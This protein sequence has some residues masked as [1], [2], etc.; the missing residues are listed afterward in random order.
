MNIIDF[1]PMLKQQ[2]VQEGVSVKA[3][4][5]MTVGCGR[6]LKNF[7]L[8]NARRFYSLWGGAAWVKNL[9]NYLKCRVLTSAGPPYR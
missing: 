5:R 7:I 4:D 8:A 1:H 2:V 3:V 9:K 6:G